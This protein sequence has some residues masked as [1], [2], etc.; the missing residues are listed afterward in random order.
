MGIVGALVS[1]AGA[2]AEHWFFGL[3]LAAQAAFYALAGLGA[4]LEARDRTGAD[5]FSGELP[6]ALGKQAR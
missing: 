4:W 6:V 1:S 2:A 5:R 3:A